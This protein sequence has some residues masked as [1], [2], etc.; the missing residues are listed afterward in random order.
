[1]IELYTIIS[2]IYNPVRILYYNQ[3]STAA[4]KTLCT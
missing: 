4:S 3:V 1:M 2:G